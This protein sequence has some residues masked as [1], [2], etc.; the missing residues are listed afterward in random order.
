MSALPISHMTTPE[1]QS[2]ISLAAL[3]SISVGCAIALRRW[4]RE[5]VATLIVGTIYSAYLLSRVVLELRQR[6][7]MAAPFSHPEKI[8]VILALGTLATVPMALLFS[9]PLRRPFAESVEPT[10]DN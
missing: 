8:S 7:A 6:I 10:P 9:W 3:F 4:S 1:I 2:F 5:S